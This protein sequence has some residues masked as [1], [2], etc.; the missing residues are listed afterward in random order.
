MHGSGTFKFPDGRVYKGE[1]FNDKRHG[2]GTMMWPDGRKYEGEWKAGKQHGNGTQS[3]NET[4]KKG[5][6][7]N[8]KLVHWL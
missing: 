6:F 3:N 5:K 8:G 2:K 1:F 7:S 4:S